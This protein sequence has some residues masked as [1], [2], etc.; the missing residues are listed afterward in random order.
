M[1]SP[2]NQLRTKLAEVRCQLFDIPERSWRR[3]QAR[4]KR[5]RPPK[6][7]WPA[8]TRR[9]HRDVVVALASA[10]SAWG[11]R[12]V[13][14]MAR[15][16]GNALSQSSVL[17]ILD[18]EGLLLKADYQRERRRLAQARKAA[19]AQTPT[20]PNMVWQFD[21]SPVSRPPQVAP[22]G[23]LASRTTGASM[24]SGGTGHRP[25]TST[26]PSPESNSHW[27]K[28]SDCLAVPP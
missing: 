25:L 1:R 2:T 8:P 11:H 17:R 23:L 9:A 10:H 3:W 6:G 7:P 28:Q 22:G 26:T 21:F 20:G 5:E 15:H 12:K 27:P 19:F 14:A 24:S 16:A 18:E 13:W 4:A